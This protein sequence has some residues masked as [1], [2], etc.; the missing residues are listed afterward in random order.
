VTTLSVATNESWKDGNGEWR[1]R[2]G[3]ALVLSRALERVRGD[4]SQRLARA[5]VQ[6]TLR[7]REYE[8]DGVKHR[9]SA[10]I[11]DRDTLS[12]LLMTDSSFHSTIIDFCDEP[13][14]HEEARKSSRI[15]TAEYL[16]VTTTAAPVSVC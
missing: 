14:E 13:V 11:R 3:T 12:S 15:D 16:K 10:L 1:S 8:K 6:G 5:Q 2:T 9:K 7:S 4:T